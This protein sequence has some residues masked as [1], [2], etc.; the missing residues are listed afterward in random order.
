MQR[1]SEDRDSTIFTA[2]QSNCESLFMRL[3]LSDQEI[4]DAGS[5]IRQASA[6]IPQLT[7][8]L[9]IELDG[10]DSVAFQ[11]NTSS[12]LPRIREVLKVANA[13]LQDVVLAAYATTLA[14]TLSTEAWGGHPDAEK[15]KAIARAFTSYYECQMDAMSS[16]ASKIVDDLLQE[17]CRR[18]SRIPPLATPNLTITVTRTVRARLRRNPPSRLPSQSDPHHSRE[19]SA[20]SSSKCSIQEGA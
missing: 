20:R 6:I 5:S 19:E 15:Q 4:T 9:T 2:I 17:Q 7:G 14:G 13:K 12:P 16:F 1:I 3:S 10:E 18:V 8:T 11:K